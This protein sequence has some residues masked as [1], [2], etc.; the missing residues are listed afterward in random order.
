MATHRLDCPADLLSRL[1]K[2][3]QPDGRCRW[4]CRPRPLEA[5]LQADR[6]ATCAVQRTPS[7]RT[8]GAGRHREGRL[9]TQD[10]APVAPGLPCGQPVMRGE[11]GIAAGPDRVDRT[12]LR[13]DHHRR[14]VLPRRSTSTEQGRKTRP[15]AAPGRHNLL[16]RL[17]I[18]KHDTLRFLTD[19]TVPFTNNVAERDARMMKVQQ[20]V[21]GGFRSEDGASN[22]AAIRSVLSTARKQGWTML[23][24]L[25]ADPVR[26]IAR[27]R[28]V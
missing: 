8:E 10:A 15:S 24:T 2:A 9:G 28:L 5:V 22:F 18:R 27:L 7:A 4:H 17:A 12:T 11:R 14:P 19:P 6:C 21:S 16:L 23:E 13:H 1:A 20:K 26:L 3:R 25:M